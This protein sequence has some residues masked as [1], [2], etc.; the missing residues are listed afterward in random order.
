VS[1]QRDRDASRGAADSRWYQR[2]ADIYSGADAYRRA[3]ETGYT[4]WSDALCPFCNRVTAWINAGRE[5]SSID[6]C[7][8]C[9]TERPRR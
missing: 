8:D 5:D 4:Y 7:V 6:I 1:Y 9:G 2:Q 3:A